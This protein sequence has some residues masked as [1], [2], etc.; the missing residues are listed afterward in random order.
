VELSFLATEP[1]AAEEPRK[2]A[3]ESGKPAV[4]TTPGVPPGVSL[5]DGFVPLLETTARPDEG[6][7]TARRGPVS[8]AAGNP[9]TR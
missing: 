4:L 3:V 8:A 2:V 9:A 7:A 5:P 6:A 1:L